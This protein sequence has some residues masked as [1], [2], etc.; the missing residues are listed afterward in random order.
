MRP[1]RFAKIAEELESFL[2][3][4]PDF[5][6][7][8]VS[9]LADKWGVS[10]PTM[11]KAA[12]LLAKKGIVAIHAGRRLARVRDAAGKN[13]A[14]DHDPAV[15]ADRLFARI[16]DRIA[17]GTYALGGMLPKQQYFV[18]GEKLSPFTV[19]R[20]YRR[21]E[22]SGM[23][24]RE[25]RRF[26]VGPARKD[27]DLRVRAGEEGP[28]VLFVVPWLST[29]GASMNTPFNMALLAPVNAVLLGHGIALHPAAMNRV[30][31]QWYA[32]TCGLREVQA[33]IRRLGRRYA[34]TMIWSVAPQ[35]TLL[36]QWIESLIAYDKPVVFLDPASIGGDL[37]RK[38]LANK[39]RYFRLHLDE[40]AAIRLALQSL[41][42][43]GHH[44][45]GLHAFERYD[46]SRRRADAVRRIAAQ[47]PDPPRIHAAAPAE[48]V[49]FVRTE[50][51]LAGVINEV[52]LQCGISDILENT[53]AFRKQLARHTGSLAGLLAKKK[54]TAL[55]SMND[56]MAREH[57]FWLTVMGL[58]VG[59]DISLLSFDNLPD[60]ALYP[61][62]TIDFGLSRLGNLA[63]HIIIGDTPVRADRNGN[64]PSLCMLIDR[65]SVGRCA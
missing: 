34:G 48:D 56:E 18:L 24:H 8:S 54:V 55:L 38:G 29:L 5:D 61:I 62:S 65:G 63:A 25:G 42:D 12:H 51:S 15:S 28:V 11:R 40:D 2:R 19:S 37:A 23:V 22:Q 13:A 3:T 9:H 59:S 14:A 26:I 57:F 1:Q 35:L 4:N 43:K 27:R 50:P 53:E 6:P 45:I 60:S 33:A 41:I 36:R 44:A 31:G 7:Q 30:E 49:W 16:R 39:R 58:A 21:I 52:S 64:I 47:L 32:L 10:Y 17:A 20:A 46:W